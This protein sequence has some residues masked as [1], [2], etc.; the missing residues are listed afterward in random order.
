MQNFN[1]KTAFITGGAGGIGLAIAS[2]LGD[3]GAKIMLSDLS[4][5]RLK[6]AVASLVEKGVDADYVVCDVANADSVDLAARRTLERFDKVHILVNNA[7]VSCGGPTGEIPLDDWHWSVGINL[8]GVV[9]G[10]EIFTP[11]IKAHGE[12]GHIINTASIAGHIAFASGAPYVATKFAV[13]GYSETL[14]EDLAGSGIGVSVLCPA[15]VRT[16]INKSQ[17]MRPSRSKMDNVEASESMKLVETLVDN[18][19]DPSVI[20]NLVVDTI[21]QDRFYAFT[22]AEMLPH[23]EARTERLRADYAA[24]LASIERRDGAYE[25]SGDLEVLI[26]G[27]GFSGVCAGIKLR[28]AGITNFRIYDKADGIGGTWYLNTYPGAACDIQ[29]HFYSYSFEPNPNWSRLYAPQ[30]EIQAYIEHCADKY[31]V[32][33]HIRLERKIASIIYDDVDGVWTTTFEDG[34]VVR[35][36]FVINGSGGLHEPNYAPFKGDDRY[37]GVKMHTARWDHSFDPTNKRIAVIGSA[38]SAIQAVPQLAKVAAKVS[39]YQRTPNYIAPR[40]DFSYTDEQIEAYRVDPTLI[41][42]DRDDMYW[43]RENRLYPIVKNEAIRRAA[44]EDIKSAMR[45]QVTKTEYHDALMPDY[46]LG[47]KRILIS[48]DFLPSLNRDNVALITSPIAEMTETGIITEN[49]VSEEFDAIIYATGFDVQGHQ[50]SMDIRGEEGLALS[51]WWE[52]GSEAYRATM[53]PHFPNYFLVTGPNAG[54]GTTSIVH[55]IEQSVGWIVQAVQKA[56]NDLSVTVSNEVTRSYNEALQKELSQTVWASGC[57]SWYL[58]DDGRIETLFPGNAQDFEAQM[59]DVDPSEVTFFK[60]EGGRKETVDLMLAAPEVSTSVKPYEGTF[61]PAF[62]DVA[63]AFAANFADRGEVGAS[64]CL[65]VDGK[66]VVDIWGGISAPASKAAW[67]RDTIVPVYSCTKAA[68]AMC[69]HLLVDRGLLDLDAAVANYWPEFAANGK[70]CVTVRMLLNHSAGIPAL[71]AKVPPQGFID[72]EATAAM[73]AAQAPFWTPGTKNGYHMVSFGWLVGEVVRR[74]SGKSLGAFFRDE[75]AGPLGLDFWIGLPASEEKRLAQAIPFVPPAG[76]PPS[77]FLTTLMSD[78]GSIQFLSFMNTGGFDMNQRAYRAAEIGGAGGVAN[79]R[80]LAGMFAPLTTAKGYLSRSRIDAMRKPSMETERD[81][82]L[83][84]PTRFAEG[85]M[86]S[87]PNPKQPAGASVRL[88][89][90]AFGHVG[91]GGS[92]GFA[93]PNAGF[94]MGYAMNK[95]GGGILLNERGQSLVDAAYA[96]VGETV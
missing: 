53:V 41:K 63:E 13:V 72:F 88:G 59:R 15:W 1:G 52:N 67:Q 27:A 29:S 64:L 42:T 26:I 20:G 31:G 5:D 17:T 32:R 12:G 46:E 62:K 87:M 69:A 74:V 70:D 85:F 21:Q 18:G 60:L 49:G 45:S 89:E 73:F 58:T 34:E 86:L 79:A 78:P 95:L 8:M 36:R 9:H 44:A 83:L 39:L 96:T 38:A 6:E 75:I 4:E 16:D 92:I 47:C 61:D 30:P 7:G 19:M 40:L 84:I 77:E 91:M 43:D 68:T 94:A 80:G 81:E 56:G 82:T 76:T 37:Q 11:L 25:A 66:T 10:V 28:E 14:R 33:K 93:D 35:S 3:W 51:K 55:L 90:G 50:F 65:A 48:D 23:I 54:V 57:K 22:H 24:S 2:S 71:Q